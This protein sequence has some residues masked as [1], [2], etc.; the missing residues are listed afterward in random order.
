[1]SEENQE[2][3]ENQESTTDRVLEPVMAPEPVSHIEPDESFKLVSEAVEAPEPASEPE[4][5]PVLPPTPEDGQEE[6]EQVPSEIVR[7]MATMLRKRKNNTITHQEAMELLSSDKK[8]FDEIYS[9]K[10]WR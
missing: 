1:M 2:S 8:L 10:S 9:M 7:S 3:Q 6:E 4:L 5:E